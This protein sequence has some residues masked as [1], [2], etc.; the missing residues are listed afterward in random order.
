[1]EK[2]I[3][4][5]LNTVKVFLGAITPILIMFALANYIGASEWELSSTNLMVATAVAILCSLL[6]I[7]WE[8][9]FNLYKFFHKRNIKGPT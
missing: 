2:A 6:Y 8:I 3:T 7:A 4:V 1:M 5:A 9:L